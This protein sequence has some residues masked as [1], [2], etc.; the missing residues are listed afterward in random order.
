MKIAKLFLDLMSGRA[1]VNAP[2]AACADAPADLGGLIAR[3][4]WVLNENR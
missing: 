4:D 1:R 3:E 2:D